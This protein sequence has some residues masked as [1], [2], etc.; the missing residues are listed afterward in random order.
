MNTYLLQLLISH[1]INIV[2]AL[3]KCGFYRKKEKAKV[4]LTTETTAI[5][6]TK[7]AITVLNDHRISSSHHYRIPIIDVWILVLMFNL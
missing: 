3:F 2:V 1:W 7:N 5:D 4:F 6:N